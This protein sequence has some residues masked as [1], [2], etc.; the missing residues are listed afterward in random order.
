MSLYMLEYP[1][2]SNFR[3]MK[4]L[5]SVI[6][7]LFILSM[8]F[9]CHESR[10]IK[11]ITDNK[12][13]DFGLYDHLGDFHRMHYHKDAAAVVL[14]VQGNEC[15]IVRKAFTDLQDVKSEYESKNV[16]FFMIN[17]NLQDNRE[18]VAAEMA[19][20][21]TDIPVMIDRDQLVADLL[22]IDITAECF[23]LDPKD[24]TLKY[25]G[26]INDRIGYESQK[27]QCL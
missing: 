24:W 8:L 27:K 14:F 26:P 12:V 20:Y 4:N 16:K 17:S 19:D 25:R 1:L 5:L 6:L 23:V 7:T 11:E 9:S 3:P 18:S 13:I 10:E 2:L 15:P 22:D 21:D